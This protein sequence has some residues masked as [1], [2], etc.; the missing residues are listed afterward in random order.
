MAYNTKRR[1]RMMKSSVADLKRVVDAG[2]LS[3]AAASYEL[4]QRG[5]VYPVDMN[6]R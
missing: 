3:S 5:I 4:A 1:V 2:T 6:R